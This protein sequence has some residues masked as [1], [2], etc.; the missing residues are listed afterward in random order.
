MCFAIL[1][2]SILSPI[3]SNEYVRTGVV[4]DMVPH[5]AHVIQ[6]KMALDQGQFPIRTAPWQDGNYGYAV[7][8]FYAPVFYTIAGLVYKFLIPQNPYVALKFVLWLAMLFGAVFLFKTILLFVESTV[9]AFLTSIVYLMSPY[10]LINIFERGAIPEVVAQAT[11]PFVLYYSFKILFAQKFAVRNFVFA[12]IG[13]F[14]LTGTHI[15]TFVYFSLFFALFLILFTIL[16]KSNVKNLFFVGVPYLFGL[17]LGS[18]YI[19]PILFYQSVLNAGANAGMGG[20]QFET[21]L[22]TLLSITP[23]S[24]MPLPGNGRLDPSMKLYMSLGLPMLLTIG[25]LCYLLFVEKTL[26]NK[27]FKKLSVGLLIT[28]FVAF[29]AVWTPFDFWPYLPKFLQIAQFTWRLL[30]QTMWPGAI[31]FA[32]LLASVYGEKLNITH[33]AIGLILICVSLSPWITSQEVGSIHVNDIVAKPDLGYGRLDY[34]VRSTLAEIP[35]SAVTLPIASTLGSCN[36]DGKHTQCN[37]YTQAAE[38]T[39]QLPLTYYPDMLDVRVNG[40]ETQYFSSLYMDYY[41][42]VTLKL[43]SGSYIVTSTF[44]GLGW[45]NWLSVMSWM[46]VFGYFVYTLK[47]LR[48]VKFFRKNV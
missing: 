25:S 6:A 8:Q 4:H 19:F 2:T 17:C 15:I 47:H 7:F 37:F 14:L 3:A 5:V 24:P 46:V 1:I 23:T 12:A 42:V 48:H 35:S 29:F 22:P 41:N 27:K 26:F 20:F 18:Y 36:R 30:T 33:G 32:V 38:N 45:A 39:I 21:L 44:R 9:I 11:I 43:P 31:L 40:K 16:N 13:W 34:L 28:F 10:L